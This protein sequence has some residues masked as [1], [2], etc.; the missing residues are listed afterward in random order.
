LPPELIAET[1]VEPRDAGRL[2]V[3]TGDGSAGRSGRTEHRRFEDLP[4]FLAPGDLLVLNETR[5]LPARL[6]GHKA[7]SGGKVEVLLLR[8]VGEH[9]PG[10]RG[11]EADADPGTPDG[12]WEWETLA[13]PGRRAG[14]GTELLFGAG[15]SGA[16]QAEPRLTGRIVAK[17]AFGGRRIIFRPGTPGEAFLTILEALG[18]APL[19]PYIRRPLADPERYQTV[20]ARVR[21][22]AAAPTAGLH[23]TPR[24]MDALQAKGIN[25]AMITLHIGL[26]T[27]RPVREQ[28]IEKHQLHSE[29]YSVPE[30][31]ARAVAACRAGGGRVVACGTTVVRT[32]ETAAR[33]DAPGLVRARTGW[34]SLFIYPGFR[35]RVV[36]AVLTNFHL[37][38]ST[39]LMLVSAFGGRE[40]ILAAYE[41]AVKVGYR[42][43]SLGDAML[44]GPPKGAV[45]PSE[46]QTGSG[47]EERS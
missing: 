33:E 27:F 10:D 17:T 4:D 20:F 37:P 40:R 19:P 7:G 36:D 13:R 18:R 45:S 8:P 26:D 12:S 9:E 23:F 6:L 39:L 14:P 46:S 25:R 35:F 3:L 30:E 5:V 24:I 11:D 31:T 28:E 42:F 43:Y 1:P 29:W 34:T 44:I 16:I 15:A 32:L 41:E 47:V 38:R 21:G 2:L 22:S